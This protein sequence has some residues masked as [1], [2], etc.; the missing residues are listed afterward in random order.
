VFAPILAAVLG[1]V[2]PLAAAVGVYF[3]TEEDARAWAETLPGP[4][5]GIVEARTF[6]LD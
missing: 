6:C 4:P 1:V 5:V 3:E 2:L